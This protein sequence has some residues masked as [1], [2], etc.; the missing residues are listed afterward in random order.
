LNL[1]F[2]PLRWI[3]R[4]RKRCGYGIHSPFAFNFVTGVIYET[5]RFY[6]YSAL[7]SQ[8]VN[9]PHRARLKDDRLVFRIVNFAEP[10]CI[11]ALGEPSPAFRHTCDYIRAAR[12]CPL[13]LGS[14]KVLGDVDAPDFLYIDL[15]S[16]EG[17]VTPFLDHVHD[18][19]ALLIKGIHRSKDASKVWKQ[20]IAQPQVRVSFDLYDFGI[21]L[22]EKRL[23]KENFVINYY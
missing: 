2:R 4:F 18:G 19:S 5:G 13:H 7:E 10:Q 1:Y 11:V 22:F 3:C 20:L 14:E 9:I 16:W 23:N 15:E 6:A 21:C 12:N 17:L 8:G